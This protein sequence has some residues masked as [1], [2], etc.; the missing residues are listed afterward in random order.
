MIRVIT[1]IKVAKGRIM[2]QYRVYRS[3][4]LLLLLLLL[5]IQILFTPSKFAKD[6]QFVD[7][8]ESPEGQ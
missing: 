1:D 2:G 5:I 8:P 7:F 3:S 6:L 4:S